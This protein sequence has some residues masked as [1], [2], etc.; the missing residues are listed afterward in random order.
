VLDV[1]RF[2]RASRLLSQAGGPQ[3]QA[4]RTASFFAEPT[5]TT[6]ALM[7][8]AIV[9]GVVPLCVACSEGAMPSTS[10]LER[11]ASDCPVVDPIPLG[12]SKPFV[13]LNAYYLQEEA[14]RSVRNGDLSAPY[15]DETL[16]KAA[17]LGATVVRTLGCNDDP[18]KAGDSA[19]QVAKLQYDETALR[20]LDVVLSKAQQHGVKL[21]LPFGNYWNAYG[22][23]RQYVQ[24]AGLPNPKEGDPR[25][26]SDRS[27]IEHYKAHVAVLLNRVSTVDGQRYGAHP[28]V[29]AWELLNEPRA[30][31]LDAKGLQL[32]AWVDELGAHVKSLAPQHLVGTG[33]EGFDRTSDGYDATFWMNAASFSPFDGTGSFSQNTASPHIDYASVH[34]FPETWLWSAEHTAEAG[35]RWIREH[36]AI[37]R[38]SGKPLLVGEFGLRNAGAFSLDERRAIYRGWFTCA[39]RSGVGGI[40][41]WM[42]AYDARPDGWDPHTF[43]FRDGTDAAD[44]SNRYADLIVG[45]AAALP[46]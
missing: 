21:I 32:R 36:A 41:A 3:H 33:E 15:V 30:T 10:E 45:A 23:T 20:G 9:L 37:A 46:R 5:W 11:L 24:W 35:A 44:P 38:T 19:M 25:F 16:A 8:R 6:L 29:L 34:L 22:G 17:S 12:Q 1:V 43:Y 14:A 42:F 18:A 13:A 26:F 31:G 39:Q 28:A 4:L 7:K 40:A 2:Y 27:V